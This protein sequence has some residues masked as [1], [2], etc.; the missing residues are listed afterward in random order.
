MC[1]PLFFPL[2]ANACWGQ[3]LKVTVATHLSSTHSPTLLLIHPPIYPRS[4]HPLSYS[5][6]LF[7]INT[8]IFTLHAHFTHE[9]EDDDDSDDEADEDLVNMCDS[10]AKDCVFRQFPYLVRACA[11]WLSTLDFEETV[12]HP[13]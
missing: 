13:H 6:P 12:T 5:L 9:S 2:R 4:F 8:H 11:G 3:L 7:P 10:I 1:S